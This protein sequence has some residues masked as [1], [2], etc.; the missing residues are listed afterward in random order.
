VKYLDSLNHLKASLGTT[1]MCILILFCLLEYNFGY[2]HAALLE[3]NQSV[4]ISVAGSKYL[5]AN[6][7]SSIKS[8]LDKMISD[9]YDSM[10]DSTINMLLKNTTSTD[11]KFEPNVPSGI[12]MSQISNSDRSNSPN[13]SLYSQFTY[14]Q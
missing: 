5:S 4:P 12:D 10:M 1:I 2:S 8:T 13:G 9:T 7:S 3:T 6:V 14:G 11:P